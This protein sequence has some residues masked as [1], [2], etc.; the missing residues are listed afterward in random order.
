MWSEK[1]R[2]GEC[3]KTTPTTELTVY[4]G[5]PLGSF[6]EAEK[7][8]VVKGCPGAVPLLYFFSLSGL[9]ALLIQRLV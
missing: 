3:D 2:T 9:C 1:G 6:S 7:D 8:L 4:F 5:L